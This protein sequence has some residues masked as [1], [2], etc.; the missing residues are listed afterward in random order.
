MTSQI[1]HIDEDSNVAIDPQNFVALKPQKIEL[2]FSFIE[3]SK[4]KDDNL[5]F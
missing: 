5:I 3:K 2:D 1:H 4:P